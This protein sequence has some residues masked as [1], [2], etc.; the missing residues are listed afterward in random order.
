MTRP[1]RSAPPPAMPIG[2]GLRDPAFF[3]QPAPVLAE[4]LLGCL[5]ASRI[6]GTP[7]AG[8]IVEVEAYLREGDAAAHSARGKTPA[9]AALFA[10]PGT[11]YI[12]PMRQRCG[13]DLV[14]LDGSVLLRAL[15]PVC[16]RETMAM[17][18]GTTVPRLLASGPARLSEA[19]GITR[20]LDG[21]AI[22]D[23]DSPL[24]LHAGHGAGERPIHKTA[25]IGL[26]RAAHLDLR[27]ILAGSPWLSR[28][29]RA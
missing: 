29:D 22:T 20:A 10:P 6:G 23:P 17:R 5:L 24:S 14:A 7:V 2:P 8:R 16:G 12:H 27:F 1:D 21:L 18:R 15:E 3:S 9:N 19:L 11:L 13:I 25:R 26:T 28:R 4:A